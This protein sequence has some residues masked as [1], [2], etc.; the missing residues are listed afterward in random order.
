MMI[1][2]MQP[3]SPRPGLFYKLDSASSV[4]T[5][6]GAGTVSIKDQTAINLAG[7]N[8]MVFGDTPISMPSLTAGT[9]Y[10]IYL[11]NDG[12]VRAD[13]NFS[14]PSG[15][16]IATSR[17]IGG[18]HYAPGGNATGTSG[19]DTTPAINAYSLWDLKWRPACIDPRG[20]ALVAGKFWCD[21]YLLGVNHITAGTSANNQTI[22][23]G[24]S[25][26]KIP[27]AFGGNGTTAYG[28]LT[29][30]TASETLSAYGKRLPR[31]SEFCALAYGVTE[32]TSRGTDAVTTGIGTS[33]AGTVT[34]EKF[35]SQWGIIQTA[36]VMW[37]WVSDL[38]GPYA[39]ASWAND[40]GGRGQDYNLPNAAIVGGAWDGGGF[41]GSRASF[42]SI[43]PSTSGN[44]VGARG[45]CDHLHHV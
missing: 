5:K 26:P 14:A 9:D 21:I 36:G 43:T 7:L 13:A 39:A 41:S 1:Q 12:S 37:K 40:N 8:Y 17:Q 30:W 16:T 33:N 44:Y 2:F 25:P 15:F 6:T 22:A 35:T 4:F 28:D 11:C 23:D 31:Y 18:F 10:A 38:G 32:N 20:M 27:L 34:D 29:W 24:A 19:G 45:A 3:V 42:W